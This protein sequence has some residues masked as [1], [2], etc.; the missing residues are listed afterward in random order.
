MSD[1]KEPTRIVAASATSAGSL[2]AKTLLTPKA[3]KTRAKVNVPPD[4]VMPIVFVPGIMGSNLKASAGNRALKRGEPAWRPPNGDEA[5]SEVSRWKSRGSAARQK[6]LNGPTVEVDDSAA[7]RLDPLH[8]EIGLSADE[9][10]ENGWGEVHSDSYQTILYALRRQFHRF[11]SPQLTHGAGNTLSNEWVGLNVQIGRASW[12]E[13]SGLLSQLT[14]CDVRALADFHY[15]VYACGYNWLNSNAVSA[16]ALKQRIEKIIKKW[17]DLGRKCDKVILVTHSMGGLVARACAKQIPE[18]IAGIVHGCMPAFGAPACYRR[19]ACGTETCSPSKGKLENY[20]MSQIAIILGNSAALTVPVIGNSAGA[21]ELL[22]THL[23]PAPWLFAS[24]KPRFGEERLFPL[25][26]ENPY[27]FYADLRPWY[28]LID[29]ELL[30]PSHTYADAVSEFQKNVI[31]AE[32]FHREILGN[33]YHP[34][35]YAFFGAD[36]K[37]LA[38]GSFTWS[39][40]AETSGITEATLL[41][42]Q[43]EVR[44]DDGGR[45]VRIMANQHLQFSP[46]VQNEV[47]DGTVPIQSGQGPEGQAIRTFSCD[48]FDHQGGFNNESMIYLTLLLV[49][50]IALKN[51]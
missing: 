34:H 9:A 36:E 30:D 40:N 35:T 2:Q 10:K 8:A 42:G 45:Q 7:T 38:Y 31:K 28:R 1:A 5:I 26:F 29:P 19:V 4:R 17:Q 46:S 16:T 43:I 12:R 6:I 37:Q 18:K 41:N 39:A 24:V 13:G 47:G 32:V 22:P 33:Y 20:K 15:P 23:Y 11:I 48:G 21:L 27:K 49:S 25:R 14:D 3:C 50:R 44:R 51:V